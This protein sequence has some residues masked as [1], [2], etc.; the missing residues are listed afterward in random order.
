MLE[1]SIRIDSCGATD[2]GKM[3]SVNED[4]FLIAA[5]GKTV[6]VQQTSLAVDDQTRLLSSTQGK[7][8]AVADGI[9]GYSGGK[10]ASALT[11]SS[12]IDY[13]LEMM[14]WFFRLDVRLEG[15]LREELSTALQRAATRV[16]Y[17]AKSA[18]QDAHMGTTLTMAYLLW[19]RAYVVHV[20][21]SRCYV[22]RRGQLKQ[23]T[24]DH[25]I[26]QQL[27]AKGAMAATEAEESR[28]SHVLYKSIAADGAP[29]EPDV[30]K[31]D[32]HPED[33]LLLCTDGLTKQLSDADICGL[34][35]GTESARMVRRL[36]EAANLRGGR[37]NVTAVAARFLG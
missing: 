7:L 13:V 12:V 19:P 24:T 26:A 29:V 28:W 2:R 37:D 17:A 9:G 16:A 30:Y 4:Q 35:D 27:V 18:P 22:K 33:I 23:L 20:G 15:D 25:S 11:I 14:P 31:V 8:L 5:L 34:L 1:N 10:R 32:L 21:D 6:V 3:A 36:I